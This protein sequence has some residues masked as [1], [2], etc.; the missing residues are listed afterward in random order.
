MEHDWAET[1]DFYLM[2]YD[3]IIRRLLETSYRWSL[4]YTNKIQKTCIKLSYFVRDTRC[5]LVSKYI[6][7]VRR[8]ERMCVIMICNVDSTMLV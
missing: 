2:T 7:I 3:G 5:I 6:Q 1:R 8:V 4:L